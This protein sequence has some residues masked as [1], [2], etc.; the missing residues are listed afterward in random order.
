M[1]QASCLPHQFSDEPCMPSGLGNRT[2]ILAIRIIGRA[3]TLAPSISGRLLFVPHS[4][5]VTLVAVC[6]VGEDSFH[7]QD[8]NPR[9][10]DPI[11]HTLKHT[12][13]LLIKESVL[14]GYLEIL[15]FERE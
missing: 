9:R 4:N 2:E 12:F 11:I 1:G 5:H 15:T 14:I 10:T 7:V 3:G 8:F 13:G 6:P